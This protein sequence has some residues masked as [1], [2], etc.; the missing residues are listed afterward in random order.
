MTITNFSL[1][2]NAKRIRPTLTKMA[3]IAIS[4]LKQVRPRRNIANR[5]SK[6]IWNMSFNGVSYPLFRNMKV[7][8]PY[9]KILIL[10]FFETAFEIQ[11][12]FLHYFKIHFTI[13]VCGR[14]QETNCFLRNAFSNCNY[15]L[16][17]FLGI[18]DLVS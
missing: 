8:F 13:L 6:N 9:I 1:H 12:F 2:S 11:L 10:F 17:I 15:K 3:A 7:H 16:K 4:L 5:A 18:F 14:R